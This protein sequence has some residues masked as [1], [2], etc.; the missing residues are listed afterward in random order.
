[1]APLDTHSK[2][3]SSSR[4]STSD[5]ENP[6][7]QQHD[8]RL[9]MVHL[10]IADAT[11]QPPPLP[12]QGAPSAA[13]NLNDPNFSFT[14]A[15]HSDDVGFHMHPADQHA[16]ERGPLD[17]VH[18]GSDEDAEGEVIEED[19]YEYGEEDV[20]EYE[21]DE[22]EG[23]EDEWASDDDAFEDPD[24]DDMG[25]SD[26][27]ED[28][29]LAE[30]GAAL[31][32]QIDA[33]HKG[34]HT[35]SGFG[36]LGK[37]A[38]RGP[39][40][41]G[42]RAAQDMAL[43]HEVQ[44]LLGQANQHYAA[45]EWPETLKLVQRVIQ[46]DPNV[47]FAWKVM[48]E[49]YLAINEPRKCLLSW[50]SAASLRPRE[51]ELWV[52]C[53]RMTLDLDLEEGINEEDVKGEAVF[54]YSQAIKANPKDWASIFERGNLLQ[55]L[56]KYGRA[57]Q[58]FKRLLEK[59]L[60]H[61]TS[62][63][64]SL[65]QCLIGMGKVDEAI[66]TFESHIPYWNSQRGKEGGLDW[67]HVNMLGDLC[68][69]G[70]RW[71]HGIRQIKTLC[72]LLLARGSETFWDEVRNDCEWDDNDERRANVPGFDY[73]RGSNSYMLPPELRFKLGQFRIKLGQFEEGFHHFKI[74]RKEDVMNIGDLLLAAGDSCAEA[75]KHDEAVDLWFP[76]TEIDIFQTVDLWLR[77]GKSYKILR[78]WENAKRCLECVVE[79]KEDDLESRLLLIEIYEVQDLNEKALEVVNEVIEIRTRLREQRNAREE[80]G[81][82][83]SN[84]GLFVSKDGKRKTKSKRY[85]PSATERYQAEKQ[86][87]EGCLQNYQK[88]E[89]L[90]PKVEQQDT[91]AIIQWLDTA[92]EMFDDFR[93]SRAL[94]PSERR[95]EYAGFLGYTTVRRTGKRNLENQMN[96][97]K[98]RLESNLEYQMELE[99][100]E[101][102]DDDQPL[103]DITQ[104]RGLGFDIWLNIILNYAILLT[105]H[106]EGGEME[107]YE[108]CKA[109][110]DANV[111]YHD[112]K[113]SD[114]TKR[115]RFL[116][117][118]V[119]LACA[120]YAQDPDQ[121]SEA[122]RYFTS[123]LL[124]HNDSYNLYT[125]VASFVRSNLKTYPGTNI[126]SV[127][128]NQKYLMRQLKALDK[129]VLGKNVGGV[130]STLLR[131]D[132][133]KEVVPQSLSINA[134]V[135]YA[136]VMLDG[137]SY[138]SSLHYLARAYS[139][140]DGH[141]MIT[142]QI[143]LAY[144]HRA[145]QRQSEN[146]QY[147]ILQGLVFLN[148]YYNMKK[149]SKDWFDRQEAE[150]NMGRAF[151]Q[152]G[153]EHYAV[154][155]YETVIKMSDEWMNGGQDDDE[156][157]EEE[158]KFES[159]D[160]RWE[161]AYN[162]QLLYH[163]VGSAPKFDP[164][165]VKV[166]YL[167]ATGG[168]IGASSALAPK[169][170][171]LG[172]SPKKV[173][174]DIAKAT[175]DWKGLKVTCKLTIQNRQAAVSV[176]PSASSLVIKALKEPPRD[177][178]KEKNIKHTKSIPLDE[179]IEIA[180]KMR[181]KSLAK[182]LTGTVREILGTAFSVGC[183][184]DGQSPKDIQE[185]IANN[186]IEIPEE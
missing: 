93:S 68:A 21:E 48:G 58:D 64:K 160:L 99:E 152:I 183:K 166:I 115:P 65:T 82:G 114:P 61:D 9:G 170:G 124:F 79:C 148:R 16:A 155:Y 176:V 142:F 29:F 44:I 23:E 177:R 74:L 46:I 37:A 47:Y 2:N 182:D 140:Q 6:D 1:M 67:K 125:T 96:L 113:D 32:N 84:M 181:H 36:R 163:T 100:L 89:L 91:E 156:K 149:E 35:G 157:A 134:L 171:P 161:A 168:E 5:L 135:L 104:Y 66:T 33:F 10:H 150:F 45:G 97:M 77:L 50:V 184:V 122:L 52:T 131:D 147:H 151:H 24:L 3:T 120:I 25:E 4:P 83:S 153:L 126:F 128:N 173:G 172:L 139:A 180:R 38:K 60:P 63:V 174:E 22:E 43:S 129:H 41:K 158:Q 159:G 13:W 85:N 7:Q 34:L 111:F 55:E 92:G 18:F 154:G 59:A 130:Y 20:S 15:L 62:V 138:T 19:D 116:I 70:K 14:D 162:L 80:D 141:P 136:Q 112:K 167:R 42:R 98:R 146:R 75:N 175:Q 53:A 57:A 27:D 40:K 71:L 54:N 76:L 94:Y 102:K 86:R 132:N 101:A 119:H 87:T 109:A 164:N 81:A 144:L 165:E 185:Q 123:T 26:V 90:R 69:I 179:I 73:G 49:V 28:A 72:R 8:E 108:V 145:M 106:E 186:E 103:P 12:A 39:K 118:L 121:T 117:S 127:Q 133:D 51:G 95:F 110:K 17:A 105:I 31:E 56:Q 107:A 11:S 178:K 137:R 169:I 143:A 88:L 30:D 78:N